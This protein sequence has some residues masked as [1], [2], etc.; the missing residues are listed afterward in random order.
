M[1]TQ[2]TSRGRE[3]PRDPHSGP[4]GNVRPLGETTQDRLIN[5]NLWIKSQLKAGD[6][7][8]YVKVTPHKLGTWEAAR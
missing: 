3:G 8:K 7:R 2:I 4:D 5:L 1:S 6:F